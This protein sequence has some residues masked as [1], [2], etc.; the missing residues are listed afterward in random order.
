MNSILKQWGINE[1]CGKQITETAWEI[2][3]KY[4]LKEYTDK[5]ALD[6]NIKFI[7]ELKQ[8]NIPVTHI[9]SNENGTDFATESDKYYLLTERLKGK[10]AVTIREWDGMP[11]QMGKIIGELHKAFLKIHIDD[12]IWEN[13]LLDEMQGWIFDNFEKDH[14]NNIDRKQYEKT[15]SNLKK[16]YDV[17]PKQLIHRDVHFGNFLFSDGEFSGY[18]D[19][20]LSQ[21]NIRIFDVCYFLLGLL[22]EEE[23]QMSTEEWFRIVKDTVAGYNSVMHLKREEYRAIPYVMQSI[24]VLFISYSLGVNDKEGLQSSKVL[25][26]LIL[27]R[28]KDLI[29]LHDI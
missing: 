7:N 6:R 1:N 9:I 21:T 15:L 28:E 14:W 2:G 22:V 16:Y 20:D 5:K 8:N 27:E 17:L 10:N 24:E 11:F 19:F 3:D 12:E 25:Y 26:N 13:S 23:N 18:I 29:A 4:V